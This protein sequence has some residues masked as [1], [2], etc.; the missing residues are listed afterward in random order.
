MSVTARRPADEHGS[1]RSAE[2]GRFFDS[3][4]EDFDRAYDAPGGGGRT[5]RRRLAVLLELI[6]D[7][8][9]EIL[10][11]GM[12]G[13][14][15]CQELER[16][17]WSVAG[18]DISPHMV[19]LAQARLPHLRGH[20]LEGSIVALPYVDES[21][22]AAIA[23]G[24]LEYVEERLT[25]AIAEL[26]RVLRPGG[27]AVVSLPNYRAAQTFWRFRVF[28]PSVRVTKRALGLTPPPVRRIVTFAEV[29]AALTAA[30]LT[31]ERVETVGVR[32]LPRSLA[33]RVERSRSQ[34]LGAFGTQFVVLA[35]KR[36]R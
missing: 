23:T 12:G 35:R 18:V 14:V 30:G 5:L 8:P 21:F 26:A 4:A 25:T 2:V 32:W 10:D 27:V 28:Y 36:A 11:A 15:A 6:G 33:D 31:V 19:A 34:L 3:F 13:G 24:V 17:G 20:F 29:I 1:R 9:G 7:G 22:D 16:R